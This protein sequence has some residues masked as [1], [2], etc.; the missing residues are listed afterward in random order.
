MLLCLVLI[1]SAVMVTVDML[2]FVIKS[3]VL[4]IVVFV[5]YQHVVLPSVIILNV[6]SLSVLAQL[7]KA[8]YRKK[9]FWLFNLPQVFS[10]NTLSAF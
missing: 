4:L 9:R 10:T 1:Y 7:P 8:I 5:E 3:V 2:S 6:V